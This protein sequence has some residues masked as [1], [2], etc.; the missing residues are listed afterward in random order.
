MAAKELESGFII[1]NE[2]QLFT[3]LH[4]IT[5]GTVKAKFSGG[6]LLLKKGDVIGLCDVAFDSNF[7]TY[8]VDTP[9]TLVSFPCK[10]TAQLK[11]LLRSNKEI[12]GMMYNSM[13]NQVLLILTQYARAKDNC[14]KIYS[15]SLEFY[16]KYMN[17]CAK[18]N[19]IARSLPQFD[20]FS[21]LTLEEDI[22]EWMLGYYASFREFSPDLKSCLYDFPAYITGFL[23][24]TSIDIH[25]TFSVI[26]AMN[27]YYGEKMSIFMQENGIDM[28]DLYTGL[29]YRLKPSSPDADVLKKLIDQMVEIIKAHPVLSTDTVY[30]R[31]SAYRTKLQTLV[32]APEESRDEAVDPKA[33]KELS[34]SLDVILEYGGIDDE[35]ANNFRLL[36]SK[37]KKLSD[38][39][40]TED[41]AR[42]LRLAL[43]KAFYEIYADVFRMSLQ[44]YKPPTI[45]KMFL[46]FG[47]VDEELAGAENANYIYNLASSFNGD[48]EHGIY[49]AYE[50]LKSIYNLDKDPSRNEFDMDY[51]SKLHELKVQGKISADDEVR[52]AKDPDERLN[53]ELENMFPMVNKVTFGRLSIFCPVFSEHNIIKPLPSCLVTPDSIAETI[54]KIK[55]VDYGAFYRE[56]LYTNEAAGIPKETVAMEVMPDII[57]MPNIGTRAVM[58]QEIEGRKRTTPARFVISIFHQEELITSFTRLIGEFRWE[59]CKRIQ[60]ARWNDVTDKSLTSEYFDYVQFYRKN[61]DLSQEAKEKI[62]TSLVKAKNSFKEMFVR[63]YITWVIYEGSGSPRLNKIARGIMCVY[64]PFSYELRQKMAAN[65]LFKEMFEHYDVKLAQKLHHLDN[66]IQKLNASG[67]PVPEEIIEHR[68]FIEG[69]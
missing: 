58:W 46:N 13:V 20:S 41:D 59:L 28:F 14:S 37:Y 29:L 34:N 48:K 2:G 4:I 5:K 8:V 31:V 36:I 52:M 65:P 12:A 32:G 40:S 21:E 19:I 24:K 26:E 66:V 45:I 53:F 22:D 69:K 57:L 25:S 35:K 43:S 67:V 3:S 63:D 16:D 49:T 51:L 61:N 38:K 68:K 60:G 27:D 42:S 56:T 11:E 44:E 62:K 6:E 55:S 64:C 47:Y 18:N 15:Q 1:A 54:N 10:S 17:L 7:F 33:A 39:T 23:N 50:W 30:E 9:V